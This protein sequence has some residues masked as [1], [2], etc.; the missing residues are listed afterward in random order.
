MAQLKQQK[1]TDA[2]SNMTKVVT[3]LPDSG[4][5]LLNLAIIYENMGKRENAV[6]YFLKAYDKLGQAVMEFVKSDVF[7][8]LKQEPEV[9]KIL[10]KYADKE[11]IQQ[12]STSGSKAE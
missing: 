11:K 2:L 4:E 5:P 12:P 6:R 8:P 1:Y 9:A 10:E 7:N 3:L